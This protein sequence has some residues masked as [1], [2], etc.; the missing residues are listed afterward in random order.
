[1]KFFKI[2]ASFVIGTLFLASC[3]G[4]E[5]CVTTGLT[6]GKDIKP[7]LSN[8][9]N[10]GCHVSNAAIGS[11]ANYEDTKLYVSFGRILGSVKHEKGFSP[12]PKGSSKW[13]DCNISKLDAWIKAGMPE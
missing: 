5:E 8:C 2:L 1:M 6:Y 9:A 11:L 4:D 10:A 13:S 12:M 3:G 7:L